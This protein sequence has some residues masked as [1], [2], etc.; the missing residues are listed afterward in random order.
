MRSGQGWSAP[1]GV[2]TAASLGRL[3]RVQRAGA[4]DDDELAVAV[5]AG[6]EL[7]GAS[8]RADDAAGDDLGASPR[9]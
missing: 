3:L 9:T 6:D 1:A 5:A 4:A 8:M 2:R 7:A